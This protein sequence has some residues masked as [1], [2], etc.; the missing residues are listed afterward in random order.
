VVIEEIS[1]VNNYR[2]QFNRV[3]DQSSYAELVE[4]L[5]AKKLSAPGTYGPALRLGVSDV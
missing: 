2:T 3:L 5:R 4:R 1:L